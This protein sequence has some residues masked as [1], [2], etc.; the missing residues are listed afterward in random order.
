MIRVLSI[1]LLAIS[2]FANPAY[3]QIR[4]GVKT[5]P[6]KP[7]NRHCMEGPE[8][9]YH[10]NDYVYYRGRRDEIVPAHKAVGKMWKCESKGLRDRVVKNIFWLRDDT[11]VE[12]N[13]CAAAPVLVYYDTDGTVPKFSGNFKLPTM[14]RNRLF[15]RSRL[16]APYSLYL[17]MPNG[18][19]ALE[20]A[21][22]RMV[23]VAAYQC[24]RTPDSVKIS[25][26]ELQPSRANQGREFYAGTVNMKAAQFQIIHSNQEELQDALML[27]SNY[28][29]Y[30]EEYEKARLEYRNQ[31][32]IMLA[33]LFSGM[34]IM[35]HECTEAEM[36]GE[37]SGFY[38]GGGGN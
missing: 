15:M 35:E 30:V 26:R 10:Q 6:P 25:M 24:G 23:A 37:R 16:D 28:E 5:K 12:G 34:A 29:V 3:S 9:Y 8:G 21:L 22:G 36:R 33:F 31:V 18:T 17:E 7:E 11:Y 27:Q 4:S 38:C 32:G 1:L 19:I 14:E 2:T 13:I 20:R